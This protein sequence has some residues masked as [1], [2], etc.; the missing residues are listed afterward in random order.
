MPLSCRWHE[1]AL[2]ENSKIDLVL[3]VNIRDNQTLAFDLN[4][5][6]NKPLAFGVNKQKKNQKQKKRKKKPVTRH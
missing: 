5:Y 3:K 1:C 4:I 6:F 2:R